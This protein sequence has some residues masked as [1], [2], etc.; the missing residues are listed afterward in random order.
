MSGT[1]ILCCRKSGILGQIAFQSLIEFF[2]F[3]A[4]SRFEGKG[5][6]G[7]ISFDAFQQYRVVRSCYGVSRA[8]AAQSQ[9][10]DNVSGRSFGKLFPSVGV[11]AEYA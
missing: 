4:V 7:L 5:N 2:S 9:N 6:D 11:K 1:F 3:L 10:G 8:C